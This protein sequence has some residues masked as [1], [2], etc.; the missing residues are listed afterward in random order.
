MA[1]FPARDERDNSILS[2]NVGR[3]FIVGDLPIFNI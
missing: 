2:S 1:T 3:V